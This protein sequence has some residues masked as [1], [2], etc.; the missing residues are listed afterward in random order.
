MPLN[1]DSVSGYVALTGESLNVTDVYDESAHQWEGPKNY[2]RL[3]GY[4]TQSMLVVPMK[5]RRVCPWCIAVSNAMGKNEKYTSFSVEDEID[6][7]IGIAG[8]CRD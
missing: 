1:K 6:S 3:M 7:I 2:D 5:D 4:R 8:R